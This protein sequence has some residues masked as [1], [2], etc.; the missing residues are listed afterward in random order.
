MNHHL[1]VLS[2]PTDKFGLK[3]DEDQLLSA[4]NELNAALAQQHPL[5]AD[6][7][8][9]FLRNVSAAF[10]GIIAYTEAC[11]NWCL[12]VLCYVLASQIAPQNV[13]VVAKRLHELIMLGGGGV[14]LMQAL[15]RKEQ[16]K[17][18]DGTGTMFME[19]TVAAKSNDDDDND[20]GDDTD[21]VECKCAPADE[22]DDDVSR[23]LASLAL[24]PGQDPT[25]ILCRAN[26]SART[27]MT[28]LNEEQLAE[29]EHTHVNV[30]RDELRERL[31]QAP[32]VELHDKLTKLADHKKCRSMWQVVLTIYRNVSE[33]SLEWW[34]WDWNLVNGVRAWWIVILLML[35][36]LYV[37]AS[38]GGHPGATST[39][40]EFRRLCDALNAR[41]EPNRRLDDRRWSALVETGSLSLA[42]RNT[43]NILFGFIIACVKSCCC[44]PSWRD[45]R[46]QSQSRCRSAMPSNTTTKGSCRF[47]PAVLV[48]LQQSTR[49]RISRSDTVRRTRKLELRQHARERSRRC[50]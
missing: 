21:D 14:N 47:S 23:L 39:L 27:S 15:P 3:R 30:A 19:P 20:K 45:M 12:P 25:C 41:V 17:S 24:L 2:V 13:A 22:A 4:L 11:R 32:C 40:S 8:A 38:A 42:V 7:H 35:K 18:T 43:T 49:N 48:V 29:H 36:K 26:A 5:L 34:H 9:Q 1:R 46:L 10:L 16:L 6:M 37:D 44:S 31:E 28:R 33:V 50:L